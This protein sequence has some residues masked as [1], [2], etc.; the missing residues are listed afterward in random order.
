MTKKLISIL[1]VLVIVCSLFSISASAEEYVYV[2]ADVLNMRSGP[3]TSHDIV[4]QTYWGDSLILYDYVDGWYK[5]Y[6]WG[7][8]GYVCGDY[9][10]KTH[11]GEMPKPTYSS[12]GEEVVAYAKTFIGI[13]YVYGGNTPSQGFDC[14]GFVKYVYA[15][16]GV[17]LPRVATAQMNEGIAVSRADLMPGDLVVFRGGG[18]IG[19]YVGNNKYIHAP[20]TGR[21]VSIDE[22]NR[23]LYR[24]RRIFY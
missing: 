10:V 8:T 9:I 18:H 24:G 1:A 15:H 3:S 20:Q 19:I 13:P 2:K 12:K 16:F 21:T 23:E 22:M 11:P 7:V 6:Y 5:V 4:G 17:N 14:S